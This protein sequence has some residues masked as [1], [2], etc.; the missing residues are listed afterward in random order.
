MADEQRLSKAL[1]LF[2]LGLGAVQLVAPRR[3]ARSIGVQ[4]TESRRTAAVRAVGARELGAGVGLLARRRPAGWVWARVAGDAMDLALL[5]RALNANGV[6]RDRVTA[7][8]A[9]VIGVTA[10][11]LVT[12][13]RLARNG[14]NGQHAEEQPLGDLKVSKA[15]TVNRSPD[16]VYAFWR[17]FGNLPRFM[18]NVESVTATGEGRS[19]WKV[20]APLGGTVEWDAEIVEDRP[21]EIIS[22]RSLENADV[23]NAGTVRF[24]PAPGG[25]GTE[26]HVELEYSPPGGPV[27]AAIAWL[28]G[29][30]PSQQTREDLRRFK[31]VMETGEV[32]R[33]EATLDGSGPKQR[34]AQ[35][36]ETAR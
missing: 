29:E 15:I 9:A 17:D 31:Q 5:G 11:D 18:D 16:E 25:R 30:E 35:P 20:K 22:W 34:P 14:K 24:E 33:S 32:V 28:F 36:A 23:K 7:A 13:V 1:G 21:G 10:V 26:I 8:T 12:G 2:S 19:H 4:P 3:F 6:K 27:G